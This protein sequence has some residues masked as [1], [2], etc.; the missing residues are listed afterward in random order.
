MM[1]LEWGDAATAEAAYLP[2]KNIRDFAEVD[3]YHPD[4]EWLVIT[5]E[6]GGVALSGT[7][8]ELVRLL[9]RAL[10]QVLKYT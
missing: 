8:D 10:D 4:Q 6:N 9:A 2:E 7:R 1:Q 3:D 5:V